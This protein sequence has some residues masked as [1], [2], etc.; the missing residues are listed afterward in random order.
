MLIQFD[1]CAH[2]YSE[3]IRLQFSSSNLQKSL[4]KSIEYTY[5]NRLKEKKDCELSENKLL[6][7]AGHP[8]SGVVAFSDLIEKKLIRNEALSKCTIL[9]V[10]IDL[11]TVN[12]DLNK[13]E[14]EAEEAKG[15]EEANLRSIN[16]SRAIEKAFS[17]SITLTSPDKPINHTMVTVITVVTTA[18]C[19]IS[20]AVLLN[21][22][23]KYS[24]AKS[25]HLNSRVNIAAVL[26][27]V[28]PKALFH[29]P[30]ALSSDGNI[31]SQ[32]NSKRSQIINSSCGREA[33][34]GAMMDICRAGLCNMAVL[35]DATSTTTVT[36]SST[37]EAYSEFR[38]WLQ[39]VNPDVAVV[40]LNPASLLITEDTMQTLLTLLNIEGDR[41]TCHRD[42][43]FDIRYNPLS[44]SNDV[45]DQLHSTIRYSIRPR[46][47]SCKSGLNI[48]D[49]PLSQVP[50]SSTP[51]WSLPSLLSMLRLLFP[52]ASLSCPAI[53]LTD[54]WQ[55]STR[56]SHT[57]F[58]RMI[59]LA[60]M[61][62]CIYI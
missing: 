6:V 41:N 8:G 27:V 61:K 5:E 33:W 53:Y 40:R 39:S 49:I 34:S 23:I 26:A 60:R 1:R 46:I 36:S 48:I 59:E 22:F 38:K 25:T 51:Q 37:G 12:I 21:L 14:E 31:I 56:G 10:K 44:S 13:K 3:S 35:I 45:S 17:S 55:A 4:N 15:E 2:S 50:C 11:S 52:V 42:S 29:E 28:S 47:N 16:I 43:T 30:S 54:A 24:K 58:K 7:V 57:G 19:H 62:V 18:D 9:S 32:V 20:Q